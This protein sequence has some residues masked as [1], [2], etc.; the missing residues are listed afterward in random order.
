MPEDIPWSYVLPFLVVLGFGAGLV[1]KRL[2]DRTVQLVRDT[3]KPGDMH[4][5]DFKEYLKNAR[6]TA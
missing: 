4:V 3:I 5:D 2:Q 1:Y 6:K